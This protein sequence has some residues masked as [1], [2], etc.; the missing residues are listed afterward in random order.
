M[1]FALPSSIANAHPLPAPDVFAVMGA[2]AVRRPGRAAG[3]R[4]PAGAPDWPRRRITET[5]QA[6]G[7]A[8]QTTAGCVPC[9][10]HTGLQPPCRV[11]VV[12]LMRKATDRGRRPA[13]A[14]LAPTLAVLA[15]QNGVDSAER[16]RAVLITQTLAS[17][18]VRRHAPGGQTT[19]G[20]VA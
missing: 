18:V 7:C 15:L 6:Q 13:A 20:T 12:L 10:A 3:A 1:S 9:P 8:L 4:G 2:G 5:I 17:G 16:L 14:A 19:S 11:D